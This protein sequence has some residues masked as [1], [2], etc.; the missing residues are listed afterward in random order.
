[1]ELTC[2]VM[3][4]GE[5][6]SVSF[7]M[8]FATDTA[9]AV[10]KEM[11]DELSMEESDETLGDIVRQINS[12]RPG[13][14]LDGLQLPPAGRSG[15]AHLVWAARRQHRQH[16]PLFSSPQCS[17]GGC[18]ATGGCAGATGGHASSAASPRP[19]T[20]SLAVP[21]PDPPLEEAASQCRR[22]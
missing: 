17:Q 15:S 21:V 8:D 10:A 22:P 7:S 19:S 9:Q 16:R 4:D 11:I 6:K 18:P 5:L 2:Q 3:V 12:F 13:A 1:M 20:Q 14:A